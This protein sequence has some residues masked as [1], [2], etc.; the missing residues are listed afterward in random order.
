MKKSLIILLMAWLSCNMYLHAQYN[1]RVSIMNL[2][3]PT[4]TAKVENAASK[5]LSE[6]THACFENRNP[7]LD[8]NDVTEEAIQEVMELWRSS[9]FRCIETNLIETGVQTSNGFQIRNVP[10]F[11]TNASEKKDNYEEIVI[12]FTPG[13]LINAVQLSV[14]QVGILRHG[15]YSV[16]DMRRRQ[17]I[18]DFIEN[19]R[20]AYGR[21]DITFLTQVFS[22]DALIITGRVVKQHVQKDSPL[23]VL[24][25]DKIVLVKQSKREYISKLAQVFQSNSYIYLDFSEIKITQNEKTPEIYGVELKQD[26]HAD[27]YSDE[28]YLFLMIDFKNELE[29]M[30]HVR[31]W[32]P[33]SMFS[34]SN[35]ENIVRPN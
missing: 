19:F 7:R 2:N 3:D 16:T 10:I 8:R 18:L 25:Q 12:N 31:T 24:P 33:N 11:M 4:L 1:T 20:T 6:L 32:T 35:F 22:D 15:T 30:I 13:G 14:R 9:S 5:L 21:K 26:W 27:R 28:G 17:V 34:L 23:G 29:P